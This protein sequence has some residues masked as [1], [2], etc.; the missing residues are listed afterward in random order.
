MRSLAGRLR[1]QA[2]VVAARIATIEAATAEAASL[3][4]CWPE[5]AGWTRGLAGLDTGWLD[6]I[7]PMRAEA[8]LLRARAAAAAALGA[9]P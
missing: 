7:G 3:C 2:G 1:D 5:L 8:N 4:R 6:V 9:A